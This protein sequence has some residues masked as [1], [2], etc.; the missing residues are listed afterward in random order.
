MFDSSIST[1]QTSPRK[2]KGHK[3]QSLCFQMDHGLPHLEDSICVCERCIIPPLTCLFW[4]MCPMQ[5]SVIGP[6]LFIFYING[7]TSIS[8]S[9]GTLSFF[10]ANDMLLYRPIRSPVDYQHLQIDIDCL[11]DWID[12]NYQTTTTF[13]PIFSNLAAHPADRLAA[14]R[15]QLTE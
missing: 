14:T 8:L 4:C 12:L 5:G 10:F 11:C 13:L 9:D 6:L 2:V 7:I 1:T 3:Y 15:P